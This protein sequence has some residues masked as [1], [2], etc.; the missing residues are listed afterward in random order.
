MS[1]AGKIIPML[2]AESVQNPKLA[3]LPIS[4]SFFR[5]AGWLS[6]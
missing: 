4:V 3:S 2:I 1:G 5:V 6:A